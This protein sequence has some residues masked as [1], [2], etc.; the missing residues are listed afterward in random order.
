MRSVRSQPL[1]LS[2]RKPVSRSSAVS[3][4]R[5]CGAPA[6]AI[7]GVCDACTPKSVA[8]PRRI[9]KMLSHP[10]VARA[11]EQ[12]LIHALVTC[13]T[14]VGARPD[15]FGGTPSCQYNDQVRGDLGGTSQPALYY[16]RTLRARR[17]ERPSP[18]VVLCRVSRYE[19]DPVCVVAPFERSRQRATRWRSR[20]GERSRGRPPFSVLHNSDASPEPTARYLTRPQ[21]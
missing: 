10:E 2:P 1:V 12:D 5:A 20:Y 6:G 13:F 11:I 14:T 3:H 21:R 4:L 7:C 8:S 19:P 17:R 16:D 9:P 18:S 15:G